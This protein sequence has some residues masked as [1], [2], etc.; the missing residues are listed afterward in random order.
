M[1]NTKVL[2]ILFFQYEEIAIK[3]VLVLKR[4]YFRFGTLP[5]HFM[6]SEFH[7]FAKSG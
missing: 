1:L 2:V 5:F 4:Q 6:K 7:F 3:K